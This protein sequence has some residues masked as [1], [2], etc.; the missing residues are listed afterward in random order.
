MLYAIFEI[1]ITQTAILLSFS[2]ALGGFALIF[3]AL[4]GPGK[5]KN[6]GWEEFWENNSWDENFWNE[7]FLGFGD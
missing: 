2:L 4:E 1:A 7:E 3:G 6:P 5:A